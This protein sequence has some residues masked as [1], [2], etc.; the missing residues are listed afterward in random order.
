MKRQVLVDNAHVYEDLCMGPRDS[1]TQ[2]PIVAD[3]A[4]AFTAADAIG[5]MT[6]VT[7][8]KSPFGIQR[9]APGADGTDAMVMEIIPACGILVIRRG[10]E[11]LIASRADGS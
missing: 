8:K 11:L 9:Y 6:E 4:E 2:Q 1:A 3:L 5:A 7:F 10:R